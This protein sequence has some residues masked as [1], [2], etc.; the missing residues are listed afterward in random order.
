MVQFAKETKVV[1][2]NRARRRSHS[3]K[4]IEKDATQTRRK[5]GG[6]AQEEQDWE[7][8][9]EG[10]GDEEAQVQET[11]RGF[12]FL[13]FPRE[14][15]DEI[16]IHALAPQPTRVPLHQNTSLSKLVIYPG[17]LPPFAFA[18]K[19]IHGE[20]ILAFFS[21]TR[22]VFD[23]SCVITH[24]RFLDFLSQFPSG[25]DAVRMLAYLN[26]HRYGDA[27]L[28]HR[29]DT[30]IFSANGLV[31]RLPGIT[32][33]VLHISSSDVMDFYRTEHSSVVG[34]RLKTKDEMKRQFHFEGLFDM[35]KLRRLRVSDIKAIS[36]GHAD[37]KRTSRKIAET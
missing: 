17:A 18:S 23:T 28:D 1:R 9:F 12:D 35:S 13:D 7:D 11:R 14:L 26:L 15:R 22:F 36:I 8:I 20:V 5:D 24:Q 31:S 30:D 29:R 4:A 32:S 16:Y 6:T 25:T 34:K 37:V 21:R 19:Q 33:L 2:R 10:E 3:T 27:E